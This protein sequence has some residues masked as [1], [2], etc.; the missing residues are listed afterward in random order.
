M[1]LYP[2]RR[3]IDRLACLISI[4]LHAEGER[5]WVTVVHSGFERLPVEYRKRMFQAYREG[6]DHVI[7]RCAAPSAYLVAAGRRESAPA[8]RKIRRGR[9][10]LVHSWGVR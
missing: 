3:S 10:R 5:T 2:L 7:W 6:W 9:H 4:T 8:R 1:P